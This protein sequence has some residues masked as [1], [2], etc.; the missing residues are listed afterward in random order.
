MRNS[1]IVKQQRNSMFVFPAFN[2]E[3]QTRKKT[4]K[5]CVNCKSRR[6][7]C[8]FE[9][10]FEQKGCVYCIKNKLE[11]DLVK[12]IHVSTNA[13]DVQEL[14]SIRL[15]QTHKRRKRSTQP[16]TEAGKELAKAVDLP[17]NGNKEPENLDPAVVPPF[18]GTPDRLPRDQFINHVSPMTPNNS[19]L[20]PLVPQWDNAQAYV[21]Y[22]NS[23]KRKSSASD[24]VGGGYNGSNLSGTP[25]TPMPPPKSVGIV[26]P[27][28]PFQ[29]SSNSSPVSLPKEMITEN[30]L[31]KHFG[32]HLCGP[33]LTSSM[34]FLIEPK[35]KAIAP[36]GQLSSAAFQFLRDIEA[37]TI[38]SKDFLLE[39]QDIK[40]LAR[41]FFVKFNRVFPIVPEQQF[42]EDFNGGNCPTLL[43]LAIMNISMRD[44]LSR[45]IL[46][47]VYVRH[48]KS[49][50]NPYVTRE[51]AYEHAVKIAMKIRHL[52]LH[53]PALDDNNKLVRLIS[54]FSLITSYSF[55][56]RE[57]ET[58]TSD[59][60]YALNC[61]VSLKFHQVSGNSEIDNYGRNM[62]L[63]CQCL[64]RIL[65]II[66]VGQVTEYM[67][68]QFHP[69][70]DLVNSNAFLSKLM[71]M[72]KKVTSHSG[73]GLKSLATKEFYLCESE[74][75]G[76]NWPIKPVPINQT[77]PDLSE[78]ESPYSN[79]IAQFTS[80]F[81]RLL[82]NAYILKNCKD[83][84]HALI[85]A[86]NILYYLYK[87]NE[88]VMMPLPMIAWCLHISF[89]RLYTHCAETK[90]LPDRFEEY[91]QIIRVRV[92]T[93][94][95]I[96]HI[97]FYGVRL[98]RII[99]ESLDSEL[100]E[101]KK[102]LEEYKLSVVL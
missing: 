24:T 92:S 49:I 39:T 23:S 48:L 35:P 95:N 84:S 26:A 5:C 10:G 44:I 67:K 79:H 13:D 45:P 78:F 1:K 38:S 14:G 17:L 85:A 97:L 64:H 7:R 66:N 77:I 8:K 11:C 25:F 58:F 51:L 18:N 33:F 50:N 21:P 16:G 3:Y 83:E 15:Q 82:T 86:E 81:T 87:T 20:T 94:R 34:P 98:R 99:N 72:A 96:D 70:P 36:V 74:M 75:E 4:F 22:I 40:D 12:P 47:R 28:P 89:F 52:L 90:V 41:V 55:V 37:F 102:D 6:T 91:L 63:T 46:E 54:Y 73:D 30:Y 29:S 27:S 53:L 71:I 69:E 42:W 9:K 76:D 56:S 57:Y 43:V 88:S 93:W 2:L 31:R 61:C 32:F 60:S 68:V 19:T 80:L 100:E 62:W 59:L 65:E 101:F